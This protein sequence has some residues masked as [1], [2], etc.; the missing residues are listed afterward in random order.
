MYVV[1][2]R[3][4]LFIYFLEIRWNIFIPL[5]VNILA[6]PKNS[7]ITISFERGIWNICGNYKGISLWTS[8]ENLLADI[9]VQGRKT[10]GR[11]RLLTILVA[12]TID[13]EI[14]RT[15]ERHEHDTVNQEIL[16]KIL[17]KLGCPVKSISIT[18]KLNTDILARIIFHG[19][20]GG[21]KQ[22]CKLA[23]ILNGVYTWLF[24]SG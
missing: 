15:A 17:A 6:D 10:S 7:D 3:F 4:F 2:F 9:V 8:P 22:G 21:V 24:F 18:E 1:F 16:D 20:N 12:E 5:Y 19:F 11:K 13:G 23:T 14:Q